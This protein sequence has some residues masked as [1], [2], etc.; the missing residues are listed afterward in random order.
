M[1]SGIYKITDKRNKKVYIGRAIDLN[2]RKWKHFCYLHPEKYS[3]KSV[4]N[5]LNMDIHKAMLESGKE[6]DFEFE[7][8]EEC[9]EKI[10]NEREQY[11]I[12]KFNSLKPNGYNMTKGGNVYPHS[13]GECHYNHKITLEQANLIKK[14]LY[15]KKTTEEIQQE[16][17]IATIGIISSI[18]NGY[19]WKDEN[20]K[21]P[22]SR[23]NGVIKFT[24]NQILEI[25]KR[26][27]AGESV[28]N[29]AKEYNTSSS[30]IS[31]ITTG[32]THKNIINYITEK[33][34][35]NVFSEKEVNYF[36]E[37]YYLKN[38]PIKE[39]YENS[40]YINKISYY[41][42]RDMVNGTTYKQYKSYNPELKKQE[43]KNR[44]EKIRELAN[45]GLTKKEIAKICNCSERTVYRA[46]NKEGKFE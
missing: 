29:L 10:L 6:E 23:L 25:R 22:I 30:T 41:G 28:V 1:A 20:I 24:D 8:I 38:I 11:Y 32:T 2:N 31:S 46:I 36:R 3:E 21:Y 45:Q 9:D 44:N 13:Q 39:L 17:P 7:I 15:D 5:E 19:S 26:R 18:N 35:R 16:I 40:I 4:K 37:Q 43:L 12:E 34:D 33:K 27:C 42:F 14:L